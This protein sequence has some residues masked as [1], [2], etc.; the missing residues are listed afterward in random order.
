MEKIETNDLYYTFFD[1]PYTASTKQ[2]INAYGNK[3]SKFNNITNLS[4]NEINEI[5]MLKSGLFVLTHRKLRKIYDKII[6]VK[7]ISVPVAPNFDMED[8]L[9]TLF[10]ID[11][12]W[13]NQNVI[14]EE[15]K[16][17]KSKFESNALG[18]R[19]FSLSHY[20]KR[21]GFSSDFETE[22]RKAQQGRTDK[23]NEKIN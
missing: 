1:L 9:D 20:N 2:I 13:I 7:K 4:I 14:E 6:D 10:N 12:S 5:K 18:D 16:N 11:N 17:K 19:I 8:S 15:T 23:S 3:I 21:P 22:L